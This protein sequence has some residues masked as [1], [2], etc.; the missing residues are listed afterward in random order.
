MLTRTIV[1]ASLS[2]LVALSSAAC[3]VESGNG[4]EEELVGSEGAELTSTVQLGY[5]GQRTSY[6]FRTAASRD[7]VVT[8][9]CRPPSDPD[10]VGPVFSLAAPTLPGAAS[11]DARA[12]SFTWAGPVA[13]GS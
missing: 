13:A 2:G 8:I 11:S 10:A 5:A 3:A 12:G 7:V 6:S 9:D 4:E 1:F